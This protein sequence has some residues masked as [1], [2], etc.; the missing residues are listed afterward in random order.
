[1]YIDT[2]MRLDTSTLAI[3]NSGQRDLYNLVTK[4]S[5]QME[6]G[7]WSPFFKNSKKNRFKDSK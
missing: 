7:P 1:M 3:G 6:L 2:K 5:R 4:G